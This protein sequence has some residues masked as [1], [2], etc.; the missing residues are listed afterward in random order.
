MF[1]RMISG[2]NHGEVG[3]LI[4][5]KWNFPDAIV[6]TIRYHHDTASA[7]KELQKL[8]YLIHFCDLLDHYSDGIIDWSNFDAYELELFSITNEVQ[9]K[10]LSE[11]LHMQFKNGER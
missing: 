9:L 8:V 6:N 4:A 3:A 1:E 11:Q 5:E 7:P 2:V 10:E